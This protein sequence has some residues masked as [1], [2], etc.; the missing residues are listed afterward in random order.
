M[1]LISLRIIDDAC[2]INLTQTHPPTP[3]QRARAGR[4]TTKMA[5]AAGEEPFVPD[6]NRRQLMNAILLGSVGLNVLGLAVPYI[7]F[8][9]PRTGGGA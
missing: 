5:E 6:M 2:S 3:K 4:M 1:L 8:F 7:A 9:V